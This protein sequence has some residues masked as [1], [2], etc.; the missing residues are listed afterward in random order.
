MG[1]CGISLAGCGR[2]QS[3]PSA[4]AAAPAT[5]PSVA[6][7]P[8]TQPAGSMLVIDQQEEF[9][10]RAML[11]L[12][13]SDGQVIAR[14]YSDDPSGV[15]SG[16]ETV[17]SYDFDMVLPDVSDPAEIDQAVWTT[18]SPSSQRRDTPYGIFLNRKQKLLQPMDLTVRFSGQAPR[19]RV[20]LQGTFWMYPMDQTSRNTAPVMV[21]VIGSL[22]ATV[23]AK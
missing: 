12:T 21:R 8:A 20:V 16:K 13:K 2:G 10:P 23:P 7:G 17:N 4:Q 18:R 5:A 11:R 1:C 6:A 22:E 15:L 9:F 14:L 19:V 3:A